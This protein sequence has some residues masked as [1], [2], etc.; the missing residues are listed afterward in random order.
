MSMLGSHVS[1][2]VKGMAHIGKAPPAMASKERAMTHRFMIAFVDEASGKTIAEGA[3]ALKIISPDA[4]TVGTLDLIAEDGH[5]GTDIDLAI[6]G[7][8]HF[9]LDTKLIDGVNRKYHFHYVN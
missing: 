9:R 5:F 1:K 8:Y 4:K 7:E 6:P 2:G 3:V